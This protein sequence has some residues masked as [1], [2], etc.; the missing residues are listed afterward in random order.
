M[1]D[2]ME[3]LPFVEHIVQI[4]LNN[5]SPLFNELKPVS[6]QALCL[7]VAPPCIKHFWLCV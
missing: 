3:S 1:F 2:R 5:L 7:D 6:V 4:T